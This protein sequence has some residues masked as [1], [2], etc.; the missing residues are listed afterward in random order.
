MSRVDVDEVV[1]VHVAFH[2]HT[3]EMKLLVIGG[4]GQWRENEE[5]E[6]IDGQFPLNDAN[7]AL[8]R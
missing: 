7:V 3:C 1:L 8:D 2:L 4:P 6:E 5:L